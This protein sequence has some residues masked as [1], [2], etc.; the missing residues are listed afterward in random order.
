MKKRLCLL[1][2]FMLLASGCASTASGSTA[3]ASTA[4]S[5]A[6]S[7]AA[8]VEETAEPVEETLFIEQVM[9]SESYKSVG[10]VAKEE[11]A[12]TGYILDASGK[13]TDEDIQTMLKFASCAVASGGENDFFFVVIE[14]PDE[15]MELIGSSKGI[16]TGEGTITILVFSERLVAA[17]NQSYESGAT[18]IYQNDRGYYDAGIASG[19]LNLAAINL[20]YGT[21]MFMGLP[22]SAGDL[23]TKNDYYDR[24]LKD[25]DGNFLT[26]EN[27]D[28]TSARFGTHSTENLKVVCAIVVGTMDPE[29]NID[30]FSG[31]TTRSTYPENYAIWS[32]YDPVNYDFG[33]VES[34]SYDLEIDGTDGVFHIT[35][36]VADGAVTAITATDDDLTTMN[37]TAEQFD[38]YTGQIIDSQSLEV[39]AISGATLTSTDIKETMTELFENK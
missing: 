12:T 1:T 21:H 5:T 13:P 31:P 24:Y 4:A 25:A 7:E 11:G 14:D 6:A 23:G 36:E 15:Q 18:Y 28:S 39:D 27:G 35:V 8:Q 20:G 26:Y 9:E 30:G 29:M 17:E 33:N 38:E 34:G 32:G 19:Y 10:A 16:Y 2:A 37:M 3:A 22:Y